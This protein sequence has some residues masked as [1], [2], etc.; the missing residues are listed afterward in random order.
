MIGRKRS[1]R[2]AVLSPIPDGRLFS[3]VPDPQRPGRARDAGERYA[4]RIPVRV[5]TDAGSFAAQSV[6]LSQT[7]MLLRAPEGAPLPAPGDGVRL[8]FTLR[9]G[10]LQEGTEKRYRVRAKVERLEE[11]RF[12]VRFAEP[13]WRTRRRVREPVMIVAAS[14]CLLLVTLFI[15]L[16]RAESVIYFRQNRLLYGYSILTAVYLLTRYGFGMAYRPVPVE[17]GYTPSVTIVIPCFN[18]EKWIRRTILSCIDQDYPADRLELI[19]VDDGSTDGSV[20]AIKD[21]VRELFEQGGRFDVSRRV[22]VFFQRRNQGKRE[23]M[24]L[25]VRCCRT[26]LV[27]FVDSDSFL[28]PDAIRC[29]V[30]PLRDPKVAGVTGRTD[31]ANGY[32]NWLTKMQCVRYYISFRIMKAAEAVFDCVMCLSGPL[33][34]YRLS[35]VREVLEP[36][37][38]QTFLGQRATFGDDRSL[39]NFIVR[40]HRTAYQDTAVC[41]TV[42]PETSRVFLRQQMRWKRSWLRESLNAASFMWRKEPMMAFTYYVGLLV[43]LLAPII[44]LYNL[45]YVPLT[46]HVFP[47]TFLLGL[48]MMALMMSF[49]QLLLRRSSLWGY[50]L[51]FCLYYEAVLLWQMPWAWVTFWVSDWGTRGSGAKRESDRQGAAVPVGQ[52][53]RAHAGQ[54]G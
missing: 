40:H 54:R 8:R 12:A 27:A 5:R 43:P 42:V 23:A 41:S 36:W 1:A 13:L 39:T 47:T 34:C 14:A 17:E 45:V 30:Q 2:E 28:E 26:E 7:G 52:G 18:E 37:L 44:V 31:V 32:V 21:T 4:L 24:G 16:M 46:L 25:G 53:R 48:L 51:L 10:D 9:P 22:R 6:E 29:L 20:Q 19:I 50:G 11:G 38:G 49:M 33:S 35:A 3:H 15:L